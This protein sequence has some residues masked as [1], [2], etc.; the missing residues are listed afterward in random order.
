MKSNTSEPQHAEAEPQTFRLRELRRIITRHRRQ[1]EQAERS[2]RDW[3]TSWS[4]NERVMD[5]QL[6]RIGNQLT[7][8]LQKQARLRAVGGEEF[9]EN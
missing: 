4:A 3:Q 5:E 8:R 2:F 1:H 7:N 6:T 9:T